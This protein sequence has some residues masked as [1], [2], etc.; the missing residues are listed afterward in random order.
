[1]EK[2]MMVDFFQKRAC[3]IKMVVGVKYLVIVL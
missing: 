3:A 1:M 2:C